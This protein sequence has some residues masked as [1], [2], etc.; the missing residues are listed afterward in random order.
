MEFDQ[1]SLMLP[2]HAHSLRLV[3]N[4]DDPK[5]EKLVEQFLKTPIARVQ[6]GHENLVCVQINEQD[7]FIKKTGESPVDVEVILN[8]GEVFMKCDKLQPASVQI[9]EYLRMLE[10]VVDYKTVNYRGFEVCRV[11]S[12]GLNDEIYELRKKGQRAIKLTLAVDDP[13]IIRRIHGMIDRI[14]SYS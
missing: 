1:K 4:L 6:L 10:D 14:L 13:D 2:E 3:I 5:A 7:I 12:E 11:G 8:T 9:L